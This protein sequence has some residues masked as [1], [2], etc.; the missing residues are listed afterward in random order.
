MRLKL[1]ENGFQVL[2]EA[3]DGWEAVAKVAEL[4]PG[5]GDP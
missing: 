3:K 5:P 2:A 4:Q 1:L